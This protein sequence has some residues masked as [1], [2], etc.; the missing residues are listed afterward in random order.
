MVSSLTTMGDTKTG[1]ER[2][3]L[4][5]L[6]QLERRLAEAELEGL[7]EPAELPEF[8]GDGRLLADEPAE[9]GR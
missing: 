5:K 3:G 9:D 7:D 1:R 8:D 6:A 2:K 4:D